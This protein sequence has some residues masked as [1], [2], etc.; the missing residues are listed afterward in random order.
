MT[1]DTITVEYYYEKI[2]DPVIPDNPEVPKTGDNIITYV[3]ILLI[4]LCGL[5][6][7]IYVIKN[8]KQTL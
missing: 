3:L 2:N 7:S 8:K 5:V 1:E 4:S 6:L